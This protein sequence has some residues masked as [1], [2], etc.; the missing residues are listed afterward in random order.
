MTHP[1]KSPLKGAVVVVAGAALLGACVEEQIL[2]DV[3]LQ[4]RAAVGL[5]P[6]V[7]LNNG[8]PDDNDPLGL[9]FNWVPDVG[10]PNGG[11]PRGDEDLLFDARARS[12]SFELIAFVDGALAARGTT[13]PVDLPNEAGALLEVPMLLAPGGFVGALDALPPAIGDDAC[14]S[15]DQEGRV[16]VVGGSGSNQSGYV[17]RETFDVVGL[18]GATLAGAVDPG[19]VAFDGTVV[20]VTG[21]PNITRIR[22]ID[23]DSEVVVEVDVAGAEAAGAFAAKSLEDYWVFAANRVELVDKNGASI[24]F[25]AGVDVVDVEVLPAGDAVVLTEDGALLLYER[26]DEG[27]PTTL[28][29]DGGVKA[30]GRRFDD[31][32]AISAADE[33]LLIDGIAGVLR[34]ALG[35]GVV[36]SFTVLS[37]NTVVVIEGNQLRVLAVDDDGDPLPDL[38]IPLLRPRTHVSAIPGDTLILAGGDGEGLDA[39]SLKPR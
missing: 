7:V 20:A 19:C 32:V 9:S 6:L 18:Q 14:F 34:S 24:G 16:F 35:T 26:A 39:I 31:V 8:E 15:A 10:A 37:D 22:E 25:T 38:V 4:V 36:T 3:D 21:S 17:L 5:D 30:I 33:L 28:A 11:D 27:I 13:P 2:F 23:G 29:P 1:L 12:A